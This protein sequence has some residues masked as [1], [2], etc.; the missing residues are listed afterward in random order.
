[1]TNR[2]PERLHVFLEVQRETL[3]C[4]RP[5]S[6]HDVREIGHEPVYRSGAAAFV[7]AHIELRAPALVHS[8]VTIEHDADAGPRKMMALQLHFA[9]V[10]GAQPSDVPAAVFS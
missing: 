10:R 3:R 2:V 7:T 4:R 6:R 8:E 9:P 1:M 5:H